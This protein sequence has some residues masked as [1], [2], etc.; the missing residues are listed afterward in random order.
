[1]STEELTTFIYLCKI[2]NFTLVASKLNV[3]QSTVTNRIS[4]LEKEVGCRLFNRPAK[5]VSLTEQGEIFLKYAERILELQE[6]SVEEINATKAHRRKFYIGAINAAYEVYARPL[7][8]KCMENNDETCTKVMLGHSLEL[9][10]CLQDGVLDVVFSAIPL[11]K[12]HYNCD[13]YDSDRMALVCKK[14]TNAFPN[15]I[16]KE[17]LAEISYLMCDLTLSETGQFIRSLFPK[18]H[19]FRLEFDNTSKLLPYLERGLGYSFLPYK[20]VKPLLEDGT[21][22]E[23]SLNG[24][25]APMCNT[26]LIYRNTYAIDKLLE[27]KF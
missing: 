3:A 20:F 12:T 10:K 2:K 1:M 6:T 15:G 5:L 9:I 21:L 24:F 14:G 23:V 19:V 8:D 18:N 11:N 22:E 4:E 26:Y 7:I 13:V 16:K 25:K 27:N 17:E